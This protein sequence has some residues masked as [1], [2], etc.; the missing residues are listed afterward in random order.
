MESITSLSPKALR[1]AADIRERIDALQQELNRLLGGSGATGM[2]ATPSGR[3]FSAA[4]RAKMRRAQKARWARV[5]QAQ[6]GSGAAAQPRSQARFERGAG[7]RASAAGRLGRRVTVVR[8]QPEQKAKRR[9]SAAG[10]ARLAA[11]AKARWAK[12]K[13]QGK[14]RL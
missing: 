12:V 9:F 2:Q 7:N 10:R 5:K 13:A 11:A 14:S 6:G 1:R 3:R 8:A 4:S